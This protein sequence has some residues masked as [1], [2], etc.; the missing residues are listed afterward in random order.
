MLIAH[1]VVTEVMN[2][3]G[4]VITSALDSEHRVG[5]LHYVGL[6][7]DY[8]TRH[9]PAEQLITIADTI[10]QR[11]GEQFDVVLE[12]DHLHVEFQPK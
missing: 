9:I 7:L 10:R 4:W 6:A 1:S 2:P 12:S 5:S 3:H 8:R 11:L